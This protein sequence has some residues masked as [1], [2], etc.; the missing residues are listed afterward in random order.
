MEKQKEVEMNLTLI[1]TITSKDDQIHALSLSHIKSIEDIRFAPF[2]FPIR[3]KRADV[4]TDER[5]TRRSRNGP[6]NERIIFH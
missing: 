4:E 5:S 2:W 6:K 3:H 1:Q